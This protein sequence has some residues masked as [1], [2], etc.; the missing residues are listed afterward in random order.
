M[1]LNRTTV[2]GIEKPKAKAVATERVKNTKAESRP[3]SLSPIEARRI[4][5]ERN[6]ELAARFARLSAVTG[7]RPA[8]ADI[9]TGS[10]VV[11]A[12][13]ESAVASGPPAATATFLANIERLDERLVGDP[14]VVGPAIGALVAAVE[15]GSI[16]RPAA[17]QILDDVLATGRDPSA[18]IAERG[19]G[20]ADD[21]AVGAA[22]DA[23]LAGLSAEV[24][25][26][27][28][29][30]QKLFGFLLG[31]VMKHIGGKADPKTAQALLRA[32][33]G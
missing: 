29:G 4:A 22:V 13:A 15:A 30:E 5:R 27:R 16:T 32:R 17:A 9:L 31:Q 8:H 14:A 18:I 28:A 21:A 12:L 24:A 19:L 26:Y 1:L 11:A 3:K 2:L 10:P 6:G 25:R 23:A 33:L 7:V 20:K